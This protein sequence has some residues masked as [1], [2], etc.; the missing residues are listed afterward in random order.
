MTKS[1]SRLVRRAARHAAGFLGYQ[2]EAPE[3]PLTRYPNRL[4]A[5]L[6]SEVR[7]PRA[8]YVWGVMQAARLAAVLEMRR[9]SVVEFGV[10]GGNGLMA[11]EETADRVAA[12][13]G[14]DIEVHGFDMGTGLPAPT[15][16][17]DMPNLFAEGDYPMNPEQLRARLRHA[18][19]WLGPVRQT[20]GQFTRSPAPPVAFIAFD[21]D[22]YSSTMDAFDVLAAAPE[23]LLPR[24]HC[25][26]DDIMGL[27]YGDCNGERLAISDFNTSHTPR[28][29]ISPIY[30]LKYFVPPAYA[31]R[32]WTEKFYLAHVF[33]HSRYADRD[34][35]VV[36]RLDLV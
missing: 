29:A 26:F 20:A 31:A 12:V 30:G 10:A 13:Y 16:A 18:R 2:R 27:T 22:L 28:R 32:A 24:V 4:F 14:V 23:R 21:L 8:H 36:R 17:R 11:L 7:H 19:L 5:R 3:S 33:D 15:D 1:L 9:I 25:Y 6:V 34:H 35:Q